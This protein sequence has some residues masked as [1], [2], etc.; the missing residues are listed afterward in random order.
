MT[1]YFHAR[2]LL[3]PS[4]FSSNFVLIVILPT[5]TQNVMLNLK[6]VQEIFTRQDEFSLLVV[7]GFGLLVA[8]GID[9]LAA[10]V[11]LLVD[12]LGLL[13]LDVLVFSLLG[14]FFEAL[15]PLLA[16]LRF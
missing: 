16:T 4:S 8:L 15:V 14:L 12:A 5:Y 2:R 3:A 6:N 13:L 9:L 1:P 11:L 7:L 10:L